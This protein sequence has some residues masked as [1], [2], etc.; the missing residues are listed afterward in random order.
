MDVS[1][2]NLFRFS[3]S[4][5][6]FLK[7]G[8]I[9]IAKRPGLKLFVGPQEPRPGHGKILIL[10]PKKTGNA[11][12]RNLLRRRIKNIFYQEKLWTSGIVF[13][14]IVYKEAVDIPFSE[15]SNFLKMGIGKTA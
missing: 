15:L 5:I 3:E 8:C 2:R 13:L 7:S 10:I 12:T 9:C 11:C 14:L 1:F 4:E 6:S